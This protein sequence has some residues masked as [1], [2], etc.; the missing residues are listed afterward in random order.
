[1]DQ[2]D[3]GT[4]P[5]TQQGTW[6]HGRYTGS[7]FYFSELTG[8]GFTYQVHRVEVLA[9]DEKIFGDFF[10][11][12]SQPGPPA[13]GNSTRFTGKGACLRGREFSGIFFILSEWTTCTWELY[14]V[15]RE[16][17][18]ETDEKIFGDTFLF[19]QIGPP[20]TGDSPLGPVGVLGLGETGKGM[21][22]GEV[23]VDRTSVAYLVHAVEGGGPV[24]RQGGLLPWLGTYQVQ[25][26]GPP[27]PG[28]LSRG[29][30]VDLS[31]A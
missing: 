10:F 28:N 3:L 21:K 12:F 19:S 8:P 16:E 11:L 5:G 18:L 1:M 29:G 24:H 17:V 27:P 22:L 9:T 2:L 25:R 13:P 6:T 30:W 31:R 14:Q 26:E 20:T 4:C 23:R 7:K 15:H